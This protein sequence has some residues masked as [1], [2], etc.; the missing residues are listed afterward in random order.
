MHPTAERESSRKLRGPNGMKKGQRRT[1]RSFSTGSWVFSE[2]V[3]KKYSRKFARESV[4][5]D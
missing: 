5:K 2:T 3:W 4:T 1:R